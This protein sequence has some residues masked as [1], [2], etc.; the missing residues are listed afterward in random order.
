MEL[1]PAVLRYQKHQIQTCYAHTH[2]AQQQPKT[3]PTAMLSAHNDYHA[4]N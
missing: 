4:V 2:H 1:Q 3:E